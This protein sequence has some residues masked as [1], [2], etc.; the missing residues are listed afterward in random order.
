MFLLLHNKV[1]FEFA[2]QVQGNLKYYIADT[3]F[4]G[5]KQRKEMQKKNA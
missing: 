5:R 4:L 2:P 1:P 3:Y